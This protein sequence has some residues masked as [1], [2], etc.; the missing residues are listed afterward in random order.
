MTIIWI[1]LGLVIFFGL[2]DLFTRHIY[3]YPKTQ[4]QTTPAKYGI[5]FDEV[6]FPTKN[7]CRLYG[8]WIP[9]QH[10]LSDPVPTLILVHGWGRNVERMLTYIQKLHSM[11]YNLLVFDLRNHGSS[12]PDKYPNL[13]KFSEDIRAAVDFVVKQDS[14]EPGLI[15][16][17]G[18][19]IGGAAAIHAAA[20]DQRI[21]SVVTV[22]AFAHPV[23][24]MK[25]EFQKKHIPYFPL[26]WLFFKYLQVRIGV[27][28]DR[29]APVNNIRKVKANILLIHGVE[30]VTVPLEQ[31]E[32]LQKAGNP[33]TTQLWVMPD[34]GHSNCHHHPDFWKRVEAVLPGISQA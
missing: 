8:W 6:R 12:D 29:I 23:S 26:I 33:E 18:L 25:L 28:F 2:L 3:K 19:S 11:N 22:G 30:D 16:V 14:V 4:H 21:K 1:L 5:P 9:A 20:F 15:G 24:V 17:I 10:E 32:K 13:L 7:N 31:G 27:N 34:K